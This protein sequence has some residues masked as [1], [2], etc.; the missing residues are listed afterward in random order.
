MSLL[1]ARPQGISSC[2][3]DFKK[4]GVKVRS[5]LMPH[6]ILIGISILEELTCESSYNK[7]RSISLL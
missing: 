1:T 7:Q 4:R 2:E 6:G 3:T 5:S